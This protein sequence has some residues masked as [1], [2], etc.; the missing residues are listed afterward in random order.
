V[1]LSNM[2]TITMHIDFFV[3]IVYLSNMH[4]IIVH[5]DFLYRS[6]VLKIFVIILLW[7]REMLHSLKMC[8]YERK[9]E[10]IVH[11]REQLRITYVIIINKKTI[12]LSL[13][14]LKGKKM[15]K[16]FGLDFLTYLL[17]NEPQ[18]YSKAMSCPK[19]FYWK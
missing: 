9:H 11:L 7:N 1:Y 13:E 6:Q 17:E 18:T 4:T 15:T 16:I 2:H 3:Q 19:A 14:G 8:F 5:I 10:K 12:K